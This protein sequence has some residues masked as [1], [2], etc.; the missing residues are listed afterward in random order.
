MIII[1][2]D[3][4]IDILRKFPPAIAWLSSVR[5]NVCLSGI[6]ALELYQGCHNKQSLLDLQKQIAPFAILWPDPSN[7]Q[8]Y[9]DASLYPS[10]P[11][12]AAFGVLCQYQ[13]SDL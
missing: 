7:P 8:N 2:T 1:D 10:A 13:G 9:I 5:D 4:A 3:I 11:S 12:S 6:V